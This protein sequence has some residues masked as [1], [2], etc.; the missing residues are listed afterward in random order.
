MTLRARIA[1]RLFDFSLSLLL[2]VITI[3][4]ILILVIL[5]TLDTFLVGLFVQKRVGY[6][7]EIFYI[8]KIRTHNRFEKVTKIGNFLRKTKL[9]ELPQLFNVLYG[10][11]SF[12]GPR[13]DLEGYAD[14]LEGKNR[15]VLDVKP[16]I[17]GPASIKYYNEEEI[18]RNSM[19]PQEVLEKKIWEDKVQ[20][21]KEYVENYSFIQDLT[22]IYITISTL[23]YRKENAK[24]S[25]PD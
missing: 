11:M 19:I 24:I 18:F 9:D 17:T 15:V 13:P 12:V 1:K 6:K 7:G 3:V 23:F 14:L 2:I 8:F 21:N 16:G 25:T 20:I 22:Y 4:P 10:N 5:G